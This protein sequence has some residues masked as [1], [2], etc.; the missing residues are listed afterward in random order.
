MGMRHDLER[1][2]SAI[3]PLVS[4]VEKLEAAAGAARDRDEDILRVLRD[5]LRER[6]APA[7]PAA[8]NRRKTD[9]PAEDKY[10]PQRLGRKI[11]WQYGADGKKVPLIRRHYI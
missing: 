10:E 11:C 3:R 1:P 9:R 5:K 8:M 7:V 2:V 6:A 4:D